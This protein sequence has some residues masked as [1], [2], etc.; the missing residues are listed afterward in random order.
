MRAPL[1]AILLTVLTLL[2]GCQ[3]EDADLD[4][5]EAF[6]SMVTVVDGSAESG[7]TFEMLRYADA[8]TVTLVA[9]SFYNSDFKKGARVMLYYFITDSSSSVERIV[10]RGYTEVLDSPLKAS[11]RTE[12]DKY[13]QNPIEVTSLWRTGGYLNFSGFLQMIDSGK[14]IFILVA[15]KATLKEPIVDL[16]LIDDL[17]GATGTYYRRAYG[18]WDISEVWNAPGN[19][20]VRVHVNCKNYPTTQFEFVK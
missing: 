10:V 6:Y 9:P 13:V 18:S 17:Q 1:I 20:G 19:K 8:P 3:K 7:T 16:W 4:R 15:D 2:A 11:T 12:I 14:H 5:D